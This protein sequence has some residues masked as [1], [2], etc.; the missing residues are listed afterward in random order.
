MS[1]KMAVREL[2]FGAMVELVCHRW[3]GRWFW[4]CT[5]AAFRFLVIGY[6]PCAQRHTAGTQDIPVTSAVRLGIVLGYRRVV[7]WVLWWVMVGFRVRVAWAGMS[8]VIRRTSQEEIFLT[9]KAAG[10]RKEVREE[11]ERRWRGWEFALSLVPSLPLGLC[12]PVH[13]FVL[14]L[15]VVLWLFHFVLGGLGIWMWF[16]TLGCGRQDFT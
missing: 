1:S 3:E 11:G 10:F 15:V 16:A 5:T 13:V 7:K 4:W 6:A 8:G 9:G 12:R 14:I 2:G